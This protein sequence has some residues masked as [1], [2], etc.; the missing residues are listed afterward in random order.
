[1]VPPE[2]RL[3]IASGSRTLVTTWKAL[4]PMD[5]AASTTPWS[6]S[7]REDST[8]RATRG[9]A[10][11]TI[12]GMVAAVPTLVPTMTLDRGSAIIM[13]I[14]KGTLR[15]RLTMPFSTAISHFGKGRTPSFSPVTSSTP[16]GRP[17]T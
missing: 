14:R 16:K 4:A 6:T 17:M 5:W 13:R 8:I 3:G 7:R 2:I 12:G 1:M 10:A 15:S 11:M 9:N